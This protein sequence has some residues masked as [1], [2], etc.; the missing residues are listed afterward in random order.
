MF[1]LLQD[2]GHGLTVALGVTG[3]GLAACGLVRL[4]RPQA[5][6]LGRERWL[7]LS[8]LLLAAAGFLLICLLHYRLH[9]EVALALP[10]DIAAYVNQVIARMN[11]GR[12]Y[13]LPLYDPAAPPRYLIPPWIENGKYWFW[14]AAFVLLAFFSRRRVPARLAAVLALLAGVHLVLLALFFDPFSHFLPRFS[15]E[16]A[17]W[18]D[19]GLDP[20]GRARLFLR[21]Y[22]RMLFYYN[23]S[24]MWLH[25]PLLFVSYA[26]VTVVFAASLFMFRRRDPAVEAVAYRQAR[27]GFLLLTIGMLMGYPWA[28]AAWGPNWWWDPKIASSIMMWAVFATLLHTRL[29]LNRPLMRRLTAALGLLCFAAMIFTFLASF[30]FPG[31]HTF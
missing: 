17:P 16:I 30:F 29:Y 26:A 13:G 9:R 4:L 10:G 5:G 27:L 11:Q 31:Q 24:Y 18:L 20:A 22:P 6:I 28:L 7:W 25:P 14:F 2:I 8:A 19:P 23:A 3:A 1:P 21:L 15:A 12:R